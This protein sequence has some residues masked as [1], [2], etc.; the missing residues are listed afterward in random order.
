MGRKYSAKRPRF[1]GPEEAF[2]QYSVTSCEYKTD[3]RYKFLESKSTKTGFYER[4]GNPQ[5][6]QEAP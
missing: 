6:S 1:H 3:S 4:R 5:F 2:L